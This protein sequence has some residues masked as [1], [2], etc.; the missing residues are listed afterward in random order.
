MNALLDLV[1][2]CQPDLQQKKT[3]KPF[4]VLFRQ[5]GK[6]RDLQVEEAI[7]KQYLGDAALPD[8]RT[9]L[10]EHRLREEA[11]YF[12]LLHKKR[13]L[14]L[15]KKYRLIAAFLARVKRKKA[16][17][18]LKKKQYKIKSMLDQGDAHPPQ[19]HALR[20]ALKQFNYNH[21]SVFEGQHN[22]WATHLD[23]LTVLL[24]QWHDAQVIQEHLAEVTA[25]TTGLDPAT[26]NH[27][28][29]VKTNLAADQ[30][31]LFNQIKEALTPAKAFFNKK[32]LL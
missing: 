25:K 12:S 7:L 20:K 4:R 28:E 17:R 30:D 8:Y 9:H 19:L 22:T 1:H 32:S 23:A 3:F 10:T 6:V 21:T 27:L 14:R 2:F 29:K 15:Q 5:A 13:G 26:I 16:V 31:A 24:G 11:V 18:Y